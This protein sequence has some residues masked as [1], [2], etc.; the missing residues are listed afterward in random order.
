[1]GTAWEP[2]QCQ[3]SR[4]PNQT[5]RTELGWLSHV[6]SL[7]HVDISAGVVKQLRRT[8]HTHLECRKLIMGLALP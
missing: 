8:R 4:D 2:L 3:L 5:S 1:M 7:N 6:P